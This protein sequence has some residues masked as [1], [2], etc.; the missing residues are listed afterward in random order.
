MS[1]EIPSACAPLSAVLC[2][3]ASLHVREGP[4]RPRG[5]RLPAASQ[6]NDVVCAHL[7]WSGPSRGGGGGGGGGGEPAAPPGGCGRG[8]LCLA[9][10]RAAEIRLALF[11]GVGTERSRPEELWGR[12]GGVGLGQPGDVPALASGVRERGG[13]GLLV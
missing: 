2:V 11:F 3:C 1:L 4:P 7:V 8:P 6:R 9:A 10:A 12:A 13:Q 5:G